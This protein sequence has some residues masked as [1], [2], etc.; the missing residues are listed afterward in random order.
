MLKRA[1]VIGSGPAG[2]ACAM[3]LVRRGCEVTILDG[4]HELERDRELI[5]ARLARS[6][7]GAWPRTSRDEITGAMDAD[8]KGVP[9]KLAYG[10]DYPYRSTD[11]MMPMRHGE[12][13]YVRS[14]L[15]VGGL[16]NVWGACMLPV[17][18]HDIADWPLRLAELAPHYRAVL[19]FVPLAGRVDALAPVMP[20]YTDRVAP[21]RP[22][23]QARAL[24][25]DIDR[26]T[27]ALARVGI[28]AGQSRLAVG[29]GPG[30]T[31]NGLGCNYCG[32]CM[33]GCP[34][35]LIFGTSG[36]T[37]RL[38]DD[39]AVRHEAGWVVD[40][41][42]PRDGHVDVLATRLDGTERRTIEA[43]AVFVAAGA[44]ATTRIVLASL[45]R[46]DTRVSLRD[47][48]YFL[49]P[50]LRYA[51]TPGVEAERLTTLA[52]T[53]IEIRS[54]AVSAYTVHVQVYGYSDLFTR[55]LERQLRAAYRLLRRPAASLLGRL[56]VA[57][58]YVHSHESASIGLTLRRAPRAGDPDVLEASL[59]PH[60]TVERTVR[61]A[62]REL[63][64]RR[65]LLR[66]VPL[67]PLLTLGAPGR[68]FHSG[69]VFPMAARP[70]THQTDLLGRLAELPNVHIVDSSVLPSISATTITFTAMANAHRIGTHAP[71]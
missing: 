59:L 40:R 69:S 27:D 28:V 10:S 34:R 18:E 19:E 55:A 53:F 45:G 17:V 61:R 32:L 65:S 47:S 54:P 30:A 16:S 4:G 51:G 42:A 56:L 52:Q 66:M 12:G 13:T 9:L 43:D 20:L 14:S 7:P 46:Y 5:V 22:S 26:R 67:T 39:G 64:R 60:P 63:A 29:A 23:R 6:D 38:A 24:L 58:G 35:Q 11:R 2:I 21:L 31:T 70:S 49:V 71:L 3:A 1:L 50:L 41:L 44:A 48:Q 37:R 33:H 25:D 15:A 8:F 57:Q 62:V 68:G 36:L